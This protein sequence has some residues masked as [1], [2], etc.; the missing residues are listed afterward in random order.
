MQDAD[1]GDAGQLDGAGL[2]IGIVRA[3]F[4]AELTGALLPDATA[5]QAD[6]QRAI[7][8]LQRKLRF[9]IALYERDGD[10]IAMAGKPPPRFDPNRA[11]TG[12]RRGPG[13]PSRGR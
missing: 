10:M 9:D 4:N 7:E 6:Q 3:R 13:G 5:P 2:R 1:Q 11:R 8:G 12:W